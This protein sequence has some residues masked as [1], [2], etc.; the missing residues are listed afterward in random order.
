LAGSERPD[1]EGFQGGFDDFT[2]DGVEVVG[3]PASTPTGNTN[4]S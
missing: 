2:A 4:A 1:D 3:F